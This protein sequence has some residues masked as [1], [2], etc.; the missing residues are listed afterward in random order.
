MRHFVLVSRLPGVLL[1]VLLD[2][3]VQTIGAQGLADVPAVEQ[4]PV[5]GLEPHL[6]GNVACQIPFNIVGRLALG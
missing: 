5:V 1:A 2:A 6:G 3:A 4:Y